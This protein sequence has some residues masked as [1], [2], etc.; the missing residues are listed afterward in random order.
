MDMTKQAIAKIEADHTS[1]PLL[2]NVVGDE[3]HHLAVAVE[4]LHAIVELPG[5]KDSLRDAHCVGVVQGIDHVTQNL[6]ALSEFLTTLASAT[7]DE[8]AVDANGARDELR[9]ASLSE[10]LKQPTLPRPSSGGGDECEFF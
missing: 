5:V 6:A 3:L 9:L 4:R 7:P 8:W 1:L 10:R 2:L